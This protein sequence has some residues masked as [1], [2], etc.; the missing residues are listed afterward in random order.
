MKQFVL[1]E[2]FK[3]LDETLRL[4]GKDFHYLVHVRRYNV[5]DSVPAISREGQRFLMVF[6]SIESGYCV[7]SLNP[8]TDSPGTEVQETAPV[9]IVLIPA[10]TKGK[11]MDLTVRQAVEAGA[12]AV[13]PVITDHCQV[14]YRN[15]GDAE[16]KKL[17]WERIATEAL[18]QCGG[19][20]PTEI[21]I[22]DTLKNVIEA[23]AGRGTLLFL[24]ERM[25][26]MVDEGSGTD[27]LFRSLA[28]A[29]GEIAI[30]VGPEGGLSPAETRFLMEQKAIPVH[31][32]DRVLR[33]ETAA[34][35]G[36]AAVNTII[37]ERSE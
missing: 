35:Y 17:R 7:V 6:T 14:R 26:E 22:P 5:G 19:N 30:I 16:S 18:Q 37:R 21:A 31:L 10:I 20:N 4:D 8:D 15:A 29:E 13:L 32:G 36:L 34:I 25:L 24:H 23:W 33:A 1:P 12:S 3:D 9:R 2:C 27:F 28:T 11:K